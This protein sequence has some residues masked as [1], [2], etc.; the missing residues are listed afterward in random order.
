MNF[1]E[2]VGFA[3]LVIAACITALWAA[4]VLKMETKVIIN[5]GK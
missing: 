2:I 3:T 5:K 1:L 4:G